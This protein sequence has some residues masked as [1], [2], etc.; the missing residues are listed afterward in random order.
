[1]FKSLNIVTFKGNLNFL[2]IFPTT[3]KT[4]LR[5]YLT[6]LINIIKTWHTNLEL[7]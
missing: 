2:A 5:N 7:K 4:I 1:M 6:E 3:N